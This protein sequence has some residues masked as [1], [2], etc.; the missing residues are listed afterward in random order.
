MRPQAA[1]AGVLGV[2]LVL[3]GVYAVGLATPP[4]PPIVQG[5]T[6]GIQPGE[7]AASYA[8]RAQATL[9]DADADAAEHFA[10][11]TFTSP[12]DPNCA[13]D[14]VAAAG[15]VSALLLVDAASRAIPEPTAGS[16]RAEVLRREAGVVAAAGE[17]RGVAL[18]PQEIAAVVVRATGP[19]L[20]VIAG[21]PA[22]A[23]VEVLP[24]DAA[25]GSFGIAP[26]Q[27]G[28]VAAPGV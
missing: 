26:A 20:R 11:I 19:E 13:A 22:V 24:A 8:A 5:D 28:G 16:T 7:D 15:R 17:A 6:L 3:G 14:A 23:A 2:A 27:R 9:S 18:D 25:W 1:A 12:C 21:S 10:L 4:Q